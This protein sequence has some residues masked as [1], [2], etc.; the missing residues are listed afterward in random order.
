ML[1]PD[2]ITRYLFLG[3]VLLALGVLGLVFAGWHNR[4]LGE[5]RQDRA[6]RKLDRRRE[7][8]EERERVRKRWKRA[9]ADE[10]K[11]RGNED[12]ES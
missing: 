10:R 8:R 1:S 12:S 11:R 6:Q 7:R 4:F 9:R 5:G 3:L 2:T